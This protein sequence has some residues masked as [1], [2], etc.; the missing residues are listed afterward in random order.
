MILVLD[1]VNAIEGI[2]RGE[3]HCPCGG[4]LRPWGYARVRQIRQLDGSDVALRPR[5]LVCSACRSTQVL[6]PAWSLPRRRDSTESIGAALL[7][8]ARG[9]GHRT[10][11]ADL[12]RPDSTVR[13]WLR[14]F[15]QHTAWLHRLATL[16]AHQLD[17]DHGP[18]T[19]RATPLAEAVDMLGVAALAAVQRFDLARV[20]PWT[21]VAVVSKGMLTNRVPDG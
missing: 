12:G 19:A 10:I 9:N 17:P 4:Q 1:E 8:A 15:R 6:L 14:R 7:M 13:N 21:I 5:R 2:A 11:A 20:S 3:H 18:M 16:A